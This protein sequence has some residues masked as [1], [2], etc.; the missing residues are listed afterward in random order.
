MGLPSRAG[1]RECDRA[2]RKML[3]RRWQCVFPAPD[4]ELLGLTFEAAREVVLRRRIAEPVV[5][6]PVMTKQAMAIASKIAEAD[7]LLTAKPE[8]ERWLVEVHPEVS[9]LML[10]RTLGH[11][12]PAIGLPRKKRAA[13]RVFRAD[14]L[15][16]VFPDSSARVAAMTWGRAHVGVDDALD[17]YAG[18]WSALRY[19]AAAGVTGAELLILG[20]DHPDGHGVLA[21]VIV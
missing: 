21:H 6:H 14:L 18:L 20:D 11:P 5:A 12:I 7:Q 4:R 16:R 17:A 15:A 1:L 10:A 13:G 9:F 8:R 2:A 3:G 19:R